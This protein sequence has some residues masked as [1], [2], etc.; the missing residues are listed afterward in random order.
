MFKSIY[1]RHVQ[2]LERFKVRN[3]NTFHTIMSELYSNAAYV[4]L[5]IARIY[6]DGVY[7]SG[8]AVGETHRQVQGDLLVVLNLTSFE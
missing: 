4:V 8:E 5:I 6:A 3:I 2:H 7:G 1:E